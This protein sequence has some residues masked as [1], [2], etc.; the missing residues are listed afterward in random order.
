M[1]M[2]SGMQHEYSFEN[3]SEDIVRVHFRNASVSLADFI[4]ALRDIDVKY[5]DQELLLVSFD[6]YHAREKSTYIRLLGGKH[7]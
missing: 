1:K 5:W 7:D 2:E 6:G 4:T 3:E